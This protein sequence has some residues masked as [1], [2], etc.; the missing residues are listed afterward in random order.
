MWGEL[1]IGKKELQDLQKNNKAITNS[2]KNKLLTKTMVS[3]YSDIAQRMQIL[4]TDLT[5]LDISLY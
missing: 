1:V 3:V 5:K 4:N 2:R